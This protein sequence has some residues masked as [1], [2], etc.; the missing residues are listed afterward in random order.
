M[1]VARWRV[2]E[3]LGKAREIAI[4]EGDNIMGE[5]VISAK[6]KCP[7][8]DK[9]GHKMITR[10]PGQAKV[11]HLRFTPKRKDGRTIPL[12]K[13][14]QIH[15]TARHWTGRIPGSLQEA[16]RKVVKENRPGN[17]RVYAGHFK[18]PYA[19]FVEYGTVKMA[20]QKYM[21][22]TF[23][24]IKGKVRPRIEAAMAEVARYYR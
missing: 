13:T 1:R 14:K 11:V 3:A 12:T 5:A 19:H 22:P 16:I 21:R 24:E 15:F 10:I 4:A 6:A 20:P 17:I 23:A 8:P 2:E 18:V 7:S 9:P